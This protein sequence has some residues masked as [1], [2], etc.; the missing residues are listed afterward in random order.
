MEKSVDP[1]QP[2][3]NGKK[4]RPWLDCEWQTVLTF[5]RLLR[6]GNSVD[7]DQIAENDK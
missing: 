7:P 5:I 2:A 4:C 1:N 3:E 6:M